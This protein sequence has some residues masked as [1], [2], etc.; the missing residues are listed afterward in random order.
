M[1]DPIHALFDYHTWATLQLF[2]HCASLSPEML[3]LTAPGTAGTILATFRHIVVADAMYLSRLTHDYS[4]RITNGPELSLDEL[5]A[6][7]V[8]NSEEWTH[9]LNNLTA[10][11]PDHP[12]NGDN[13]LG[14]VRNLLLTQAIHHGNDHRTH[15]CS[16]LSVNGL[17]AP[18]FDAWLYWYDVKHVDLPD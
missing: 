3:D 1:P 5:R 17:G 4:L 11:P 9:V 15:I 10:Y 7:F 2:D 18:E 14:E 6:R 12:R 13:D 16:V 8:A